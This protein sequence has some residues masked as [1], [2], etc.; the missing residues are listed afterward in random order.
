M[1]ANPWAS[2]G[3]GGS[4]SR[5]GKHGVVRIAVREPKVLAFHEVLRLQMADDI[6][7]D[8]RRD[9]SLLTRD[10]DPELVVRCRVVAAVCLV[11][12]EPLDDVADELFHVWDDG[13]ERVAVK[14][15][16]GRA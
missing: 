1:P 12:K 3:D 11:E 4:C 6:L 5:R 7:D 8:R 2:R 13:L 14:G 10:E 9:T 16:V 15:I